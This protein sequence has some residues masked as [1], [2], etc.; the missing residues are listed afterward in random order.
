M[1]TI[2]NGS[3][4][5]QS[6]LTGNDTI[7]SSGTAV[8][9][10]GYAGNDTLTGGSGNDTIDGGTGSDTAVYLGTRSSYTV[11]K[12]STGYTVAANSGTGGTDTLTNVERIQFSDGTLALDTD[13]W[14]VAGSAYRLYRAAFARTPDN[15]GL[16][17]WI[18]QMDVG[19]TIEQVAHNFIVST[20]FQALY[21]ANPT[22]S[23]LVTAMY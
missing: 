17:Y 10:Q 16:K 3:Y 14:A 8:L 13:N 19:Q 23:Q 9:L 1:Q 22:N 11:T 20:E 5:L 12:T 15:S 18:S 4:F 2:V 21:G 6:I 7:K